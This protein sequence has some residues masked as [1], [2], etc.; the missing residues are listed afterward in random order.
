MAYFDSQWLHIPLTRFSQAVLSLLI[1]Y[2]YTTI[3]IS[4]AEQWSRILSIYLTHFSRQNF[5]ISSIDLIFKL[6]DL[7][8]QWFKHTILHP[9]SLLITYEYPLFLKV[10][11]QSYEIKHKDTEQFTHRSLKR[12]VS[13][14]RKK[15]WS[16]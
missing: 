1:V 4:R 5:D 16:I 12:R 10:T 3:T 6:I 9:W 14:L 13:H 7:L 8:T 2:S 15:Y 11:I